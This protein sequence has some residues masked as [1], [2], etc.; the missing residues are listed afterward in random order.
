MNSDV[1]QYLM[2]TYTPDATAMASQMFGPFTSGAPTT[3]TTVVSSSGL[4]AAASS[5]TTTTTASSSFGKVLNRKGP[6]IIRHGSFLTLSLFVSAVELGY[7][8]NSY[9]LTVICY[10]REKILWVIFCN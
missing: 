6:F 7:K 5:S 1:G 9:V 2:A 8:E 3:N 10:N 4:G